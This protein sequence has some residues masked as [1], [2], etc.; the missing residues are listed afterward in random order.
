M[1]DIVKISADFYTADEIQSARV[2]LTNYANQKRLPKAKGTD[3]EV[4]LRDVTS[5][6]KVCLDPSVKLSQFSADKMQR[7][8][9]V[10][11]NGYM[12]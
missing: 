5:I 6:T 9:G 11:P 2:T 1:D 10:S 3:K 8:S 7:Y 12:D 4:G